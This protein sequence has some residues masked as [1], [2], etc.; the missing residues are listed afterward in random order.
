MS[1]LRFLN[2]VDGSG[3]PTSQLH[4]LV[5]ARGAVKAD[6]LKRISQESFSFLLDKTFESDKATYAQ[7]AETFYDTYQVEKDVARKCIK[8]FIELADDAGITLSTFIT[9][10]SKNSRPA[11]SMEKIPKKFGI[12]TNRNVEVPESLEPV[13]HS[14]TW[15][16]LLLNKFPSFDPTWPNEVQV[17]WFEA[18]DELLKRGFISG[19]DSR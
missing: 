5:A 17:K 13:P 6:V 19:T 1:A 15:K 14:M 3:T 8:F 7:L 18:F 10:R 9:K 12:R 2:L 4:D 11:Q 16:E